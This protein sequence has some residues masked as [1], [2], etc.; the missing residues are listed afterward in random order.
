MVLIGQLV[1]GIVYEINNFMGF[2]IV[3]LN[4]FEQYVKYLFDVCQ[5]SWDLVEI[6]SDIELQ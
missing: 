4:I 1:V 2:I 3:N 5:V 6:Y